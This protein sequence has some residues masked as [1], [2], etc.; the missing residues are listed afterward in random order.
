MKTAIYIRVSTEEQVKEGYSISA[1]KQKLKAFCISQGWDV[2]GLYPD[3]GI[4]AKN[5]KR[6][7]LQRMIQDIKNGDVDCV[8]VYRLDRLTRSVLDLYNMLEVFEKYNCKFKSATEVYDT[9]TAMGKMFITIVAALAQWER[10]NMG[11]RISFGFA[12]KARQGKYPLN[13]APIGYDLDKEK[14]KLHINKKEAE[15]VL[16][17]FKKYQEG[18]GGNRLCRYL[19][20]NEIRTK[21]GNVWTDNTLFKVL[22]NPLYYGAFRWLEMVVEEA[23]EPI[24]TKDE[25]TRVQELIKE[26]SAQPPRSVSS[27]YIFS[28]KLRC[29]G[30]GRPM[31]GY[32]T[33]RKLVS[34]E[35]KNYPQYRCKKNKLGICTRS[36]SVSETK[37][38]KAF[39][40]YL[41]N[42]DYMNFLDETVSVGEKSLNKIKPTI[43]VD[44]LKK[45][46]S[47]IENRKK[48]WQYAWTDELISFEDFKKR[49]DEAKKEEGEIN[50]KLD[51]VKDEVKESP[52]NKNEIYAALKEIEKNWSHLK[53]AK[54][55]NLVNSII[56]E[57]QVERVGNAL[58]VPSVTFK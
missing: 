38:E 5:T 14:S 12:E 8:L 48:K 11:E 29:S 25:W 22:R 2:V 55:K 54:K 3:E 35:V 42:V 40:E 58:R 16:T 20:E 6:P 50:D 1:Q 15:T 37:L 56:E 47:K 27:D 43:D 9:T 33:S 49:M 21:A 39:V 36:H 51:L 18:L 19:N 26:R 52:V 46:L 32:Y 57:V 4:S 44:Q 7:H 34:G 31:Q 28:G 24:I 30:C 13:F 10:E 45:Q 17:I 41:I 53:K 23:H